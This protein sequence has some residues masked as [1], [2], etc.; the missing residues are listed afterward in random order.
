[1]AARVIRA[2]DTLASELGYEGPLDEVI[3]RG[4]IWRRAKAALR[5]GVTSD[6][7]KNRLTKVER[8]L[9]LKS[10]DALQ[11]EVDGKAVAAVVELVG[12]L[13]DVPQACI[14]VGS[15]L[16]LKFSDEKGPVLMVRSLSQLEIRA[17]ER[18]PEIQTRPRIALEALATALATMEQPAENRST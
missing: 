8:A 9:E 12:S 3:V 16:L 11:A 7:V 1:V 10:I 18:F 2:L 6:E 17:L 15:I 13:Q 4:S 5:R 14:R